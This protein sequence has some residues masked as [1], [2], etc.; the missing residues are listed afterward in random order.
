[1][2]AFNTKRWRE[3]NKERVHHYRLTFNYGI[4]VEQYEELLKK[5]HGKCAVCGEGETAMSRRG[6]LH[7]LSVDHCHVTGKIRGLLCK[8]CNT[9]I[10]GFAE[11]PSLLRR[12]AAYLEIA[13]TGLRVTH[14]TVDK[15]DDMF[16]V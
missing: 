1:M 14:G 2:T 10:A 6:V 11:A 4:S 7:R 9:N 3:A 8:R 5:Q 16:H 12:A 13:D 15:V